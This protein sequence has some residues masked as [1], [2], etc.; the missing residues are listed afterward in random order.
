MPP[1]PS[2]NQFV[3]GRMKL[4]AKDMPKLH[5][6]NKKEN[7]ITAVLVLGCGEVS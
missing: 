1:P 3:A 6:G 7:A 4:L 5:K 2:C